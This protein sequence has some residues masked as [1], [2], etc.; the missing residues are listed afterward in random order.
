MKNF[1]AFI[2]VL[3]FVVIGN[4]LFAQD[5]IYWSP[6]YRLKWEDFHGKPDT[7]SKYGAISDLKIKYSLSANED[8]FNAEVLCFFIKS[9]SWSLF[10]KSDT[11][12]MHEQGHFDITELFARKL[13]KAISEYKLNYKTVGNDIDNLFLTIKQER[14]RMDSL[15]DKET[16]LSRNGEEQLLWNKKI[17]AELDKL[18][19]FAS[20]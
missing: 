4:I 20:F 6:S 5:T 16:N 2:T 17:K 12:L 10:K 15:Y 1:K 18:K 11:L 9:K 3:F 19:K 14:I 7:L 8:S 13:R